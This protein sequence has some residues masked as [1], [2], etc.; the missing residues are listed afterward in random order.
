[1]LW[2]S[3]NPV[4]LDSLLFERINSARRDESLPLLDR[5]AYIEYA[6]QLDLGDFAPDSFYRIRL[7]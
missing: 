4:I 2:L 1:V 3:P 6:R 5:P 7:P